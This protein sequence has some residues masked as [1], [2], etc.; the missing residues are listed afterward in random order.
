LRNINVKEITSAV[1]RL[2]REANFSLPDD[3]LAA[4][5]KALETEESPEGKD[6][7]QKLVENAAIARDEQI[8]ICQDCGVA[9]VYLEIGQKVSISGG[10]LYQ[11]VQDGIREGYREGYLRKSLA[12]H[13]F[14]SR[15]NTGDNTPAVI[16]TDIVPGDR[17]KILFM[18]KGAGS[19]NM[20]RLF[21]LNPSHGRQ[22]II[23]AVVTAIEEAGS[24]PCPPVVVGVGIGGTADKAMDIAKRALFREVG[25]ASDNSENAELEAELLTQINKLGIGPQG[26]GGR[27]TALAV[28]VESFPCHIGSLPVAV[29]IQ[30]HALRRK[31]AL[32]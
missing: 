2:S 3:V 4:L 10:D 13:P 14:T 11:A 1:S 5:K 12:D 18:P 8:P 9:M 19:E 30:C 21:M 26:F 17:L 22:G 31:E 15:T 27:I 23:D 6:V 25:R 7:L 32:L 24:N 29:N 16:H 28:H 20:S